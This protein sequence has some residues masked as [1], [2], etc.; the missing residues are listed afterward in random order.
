MTETLGV[1]V[2]VG[3]GEG[4]GVFSIFLLRVCG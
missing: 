3:W 1:S 4:G 2:C